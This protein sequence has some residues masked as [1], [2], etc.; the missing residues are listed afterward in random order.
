MGTVAA[1][2]TMSR[3]LLCTRR[4]RSAETAKERHGKE[5]AQ[6]R[7]GFIAA[8]IDAERRKLAQL[9]EAWNHCLGRRRREAERELLQLLA[10]GEDVA[11]RICHPDRL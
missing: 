5:D 10:V 2:D 4:R 3:S 11:E 1:M 6:R 7:A 8:M 9:L